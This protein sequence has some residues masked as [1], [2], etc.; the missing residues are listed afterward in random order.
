[1]TKAELIQKLED[2]EWEDFEVKKAASE[3]P[4]SAWESVSAFS[5][6]NGGWLIFGISQEGKHFEISG[7]KNA[8]KIEQDFLTNIRGGKFNAPVFSLQKKYAIDGKTILAFYIPI[9]AQKPIYYNSLVN[10]FIRRGSSDMRA[11]K[12]EVDS[13]YR[14]QTFGTKTSELAPNTN[15]SSL[16]KRSLEQYRDYM[17]RFNPN[18][19]YN[20]LNEDD[21]LNRL[22]VL[23]NGACTYSG[24]LMFGKREIIEKHFDDFRIDLLEIPGTSYANAPTR[25]T[26]RLDEQENLWEYYFECF[27]RLKNKVDVTFSVSPEGFGQELS[28]GLVAIRE[29]LVNMLMHADYFAPSKSRIRIFSNHIEF[30][31]PGGLPKPIEELRSKDL[32]ISRNPIL[33]KLFRMVKLAENIGSGIEKIEHNW[34][35]YN[36][37]TPTYQL[38]FDTT[39]IDFPFT[40]VDVETEK[41]LEKD[42]GKDLEKDVEKD[43]EKDISI[44]LNTSEAKILNIMKKNPNVTIAE[45]A[46]IIG[47][48]DRNIRKNIDKLKNK[49][50][51]RRMGPDKG[52]YWEILEKY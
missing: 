41:D 47:I 18:A 14:D 7:V 40:L 5:N 23:E 36:N 38:D 26:F 29:A 50:L 15:Q 25:Y 37:S 10:T 9:S 3:V 35:A 44:H 30:Y 4:K 52:G 11:T 39:I 1:M 43:V 51:I 19:S 22:R 27:N 48:N 32:S 16:H 20:R 31:N 21:F 2:I 8:E 34:L 24:L 17:A 46:D 45:L 6:T 33:A 28:P 13:M 12:E 42:V 49:K